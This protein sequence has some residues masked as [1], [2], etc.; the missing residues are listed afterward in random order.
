MI[1]KCVPVA[2]LAGHKSPVPKGTIEDANGN[3]IVDNGETDRHQKHTFDG[4]YPTNPGLV[5][6]AEYRAYLHEESLVNDI[7]AYDDEDWSS[8]PLGRNWDH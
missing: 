6:D 1:D 8:G 2:K 4:I 3:G 5:D 7:G